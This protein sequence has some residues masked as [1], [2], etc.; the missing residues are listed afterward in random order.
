[1]IQLSI[2]IPSIPERLMNLHGLITVYESYIEKYNL[3]GV[4]ELLSIC[5][6][7]KRSI[8]R[9]RSDLVTLAEGRYW[10]MTD[11]DSD[12]LTE[13]YFEH[14]K[15]RID[16]NVDV[17]TYKQFARINAEYTFVDFGL[18]RPIQDFVNMGVTQRPAWHCCTWKRELVKDIKF[19]DS[20]YGE[21]HEFAIVANEL[22]QTESHINEV[23]HVYQHDSLKTAAFL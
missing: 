12:Y 16:L 22:A 23:C 15:S 18:K 19:G 21:D 13:K 14:I 8:G 11:D 9:K 3:N 2:L 6:N 10:V 20:N 7:K 4:V 1:M 5:D 17:I